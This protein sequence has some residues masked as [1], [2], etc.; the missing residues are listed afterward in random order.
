MSVTGI[1]Q[2]LSQN[3]LFYQIFNFLNAF[4]NA[5]MYPLIFVIGKYDIRRARPVILNS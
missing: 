4:G 3:Y 2:G 5:G 1:A